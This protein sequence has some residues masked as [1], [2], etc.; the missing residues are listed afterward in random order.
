M[1]VTIPE[2]V[3]EI[4]NNAFYWCASLSS[5]TISEGVTTIG[6]RA[7]YLCSNLQKV[8]CKAP[9][10]PALDDNYTFGHAASFSIM[11]PEESVEAYKTANNWGKYANYITAY[12]STNE[13]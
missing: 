4:G 2:N 11:V 1:S 5:V 9:T 13:Q 12:S 3:I 10:P 7:F 6:D 8:Y